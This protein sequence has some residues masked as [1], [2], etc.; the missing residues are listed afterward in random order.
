[1]LFRSHGGVHQFAALPGLGLRLGVGLRLLL[2]GML[3]GL[4]LGAELSLL[5]GALGR[6]RRYGEIWCFAV[7][8]YLSVFFAYYAIKSTR[9]SFQFNDIS[10]G[11]D[12]SPIWIPQI[13]M[14]VGT[15]ILAIA[16]IDHLLSLLF[17]GDHNIQEDAL[18]ANVE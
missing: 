14:C 2:T 12:A 8:S 9:E 4:V 7:G 13:A 3:L 17:V 1:V 6:Y 15:V 11:Q 18:D 5:L 16:F 10:Q